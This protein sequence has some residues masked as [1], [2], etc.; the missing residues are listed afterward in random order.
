M[1]NLLIEIRC[2][3]E[4]HTLNADKNLKKCRFRRP[5]FLRSAKLSS[6]AVTIQ[7]E[8]E[9]LTSLAMYQGEKDRP[10]HSCT[11]LD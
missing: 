11:S 6:G 4:Y 7:G 10:F 9:I 1:R 8:E 3:D 5:L 2:V